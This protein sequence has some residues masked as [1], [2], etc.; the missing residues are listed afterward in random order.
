MIS[1]RRWGE[2]TLKAGLNHREA[3]DAE[4]AI[5]YYE[6]LLNFNGAVEW[7]ALA[8]YGL[9]Q[10][11]YEAKQYKEVIEA[12]NSTA[13]TALDDNR[14]RPK[15]LIM[16]AKSYQELE[17]YSNAFDSYR[18]V[19]RGFPETEEAIEAG[20][21]K[22]RCQFALGDPSLP[23]YADRFVDLQRERDPESPFINKAIFLKSEI[24][25]KQNRFRDAAESYR[26]LGENKTNIPEKYHSMINYKHGWA[27]ADSGNPSLAIAPLSDF[28]AN[29]PDSPHF[30]NALAK[31]A[32]SY[33]LIED[34]TNC[35]KDF[36]RIVKDF[37]E[38]EPAELAYQQKG[39]ISGQRRDDD[40]MIAT[41]EEMLQ[42]FPNT[43]AKAQAKFWI[44][45]GKYRK[46][47]YKACIDPLTEARTLQPEA[48]FENATRALMHAQYRNAQSVTSAAS[49]EY[50]GK[51]I[52][53]I[54]LYR[55]KNPEG[56][57]P[58]EILFWLG[59]NLFDQEDYQRC[60]KYLTLAST[61]EKPEES[62]LIL[63]ERLAIAREKNGNWDRALNAAENQFALSKTPAA[64][65]KTLLTKSKA[66][67]GKKLYDEARVAALQ[68]SKRQQEGR[69]GA[70]IHLQLGDIEFAVGN[71]EDAHQRYVLP[72][73]AFDDPQI[74]PLALW[75]T[76]RA[77]DASLEELGNDATA[78]EVRR[79]HTAKKTELESELSKRFPSFR[80]PA[81]EA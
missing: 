21:Q 79:E 51:L 57:V 71:Y 78:N 70:M 48:Y 67:L 49:N 69:V 55:K 75:K 37:P 15:M 7:K 19:E 22:L 4:K 59:M 42:K 18:L 60:A 74:T 41:F 76:I 61:P 20:Y 31:R 62:Q 38:S 11:H 72:A 13:G 27:E 1:S 46:K 77:L 2:A 33:K 17:Q 5:S 73:I 10:L 32:M 24:L 47:D 36:D 40:A 25:F 43:S 64:E 66:L 29:E 23:G 34:Y 81:E 65:A 50:L 68:A 58:T 52:E 26:A 16:V 30:A 39:L 12:F 53:E 44:G 28:L 9:I 3:G 63:W 8:R 35:L 6:R 45:F 14:M 56:L 80:P 54:D